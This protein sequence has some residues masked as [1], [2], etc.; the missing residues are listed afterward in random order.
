MIEGKKFNT[1]KTNTTNKV[2]VFIV[3]QKNHKFFTY[4]H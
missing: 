1:L 4:L 3:L 2:N